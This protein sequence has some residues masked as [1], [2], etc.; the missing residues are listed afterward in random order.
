MSVPELP[1]N[2]SSPEETLQDSQRIIQASLRNITKSID[3][4]QDRLR[5]DLTKSQERNQT[6]F[7]SIVAQLQNFN[8]QMQPQAVP[9][10]DIS[11]YKVTLQN[12]FSCLI[13]LLILILSRASLESSA[14]LP[15]LILSHHAFEVGRGSSHPSVVTS[16]LT[17][18]S[19]PLGIFSYQLIWILI[20]QPVL[21]LGGPIT[22]KTK[23]LELSWF[24]VWMNGSYS[25]KLQFIPTRLQLIPTRNILMIKWRNFGRYLTRSLKMSTIYSIIIEFP[26]RTM[27]LKMMEFW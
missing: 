20:Y 16:N 22:A 3:E 13:C 11:L 4:L 24:Q 7:N 21:I 12:I 17:S 10:S 15:K 23:N 1:Y 5:S 14:N 18:Q 9:V 6:M 25:Y 8:L 26:P 19:L 2:I 27:M